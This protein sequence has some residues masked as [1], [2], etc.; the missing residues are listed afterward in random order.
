MKRRNLW[1]LGVGPLYLGQ[2]VG[3][4]GAQTGQRVALVIG[5]GAYRGG[6]PALANPPRDARAV[7]V[8][9]ERLGF[10][11]ELWLDADRAT[12]LAAF[13]RLGERATGAEAALLFYAGHAAEV[14]GRNILF[15]VSVSAG[16][17]GS[18][19]VRESVA[20]DDLSAALNGKARTTLIFL[21]LCRD[22]PLT[23]ANLPPA[24]T[25]GRTTG[26]PARSV[27]TGLAS[28]F[29]PAGTLIVYATAPGQVA[30]DGDGQ[31]SPFTTALLQHIETPDIEVRDMLTRVRRVVRQ[32]TQGRQIPWDNSSLDAPFFM[33]TGSSAGRS[34][35]PS[36]RI[37]E[38]A[39]AQ[40][41]TLPSS[42]T[43]LRFQRS[44]EPGAASQFVGSWSSG[45]QRWAGQSGRRNVLIVLSV[46]ERAGT[47][48]TIFAQ[49]EYSEDVTP[50]NGRGNQELGSYF[51]RRVM[52]FSSGNGALEATSPAGDRMQFI[53]EAETCLLQSLERLLT[54]P[55]LT[56]GTIF[57][58]RS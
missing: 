1:G 42:I 40:G 43:E 28:V 21:D 47:A 37:I 11:I 6:I 35:G 55:G 34:A 23:G 45:N 26:A 46:D 14:S 57:A 22:N 32:N 56:R 5:N 38:E 53:C 33:R 31:N 8:A 25:Q 3:F 48:E 13:R 10:Q 7:S 41:I 49:S 54:P 18:D 19:L 50:R 20:Y 51:R 52:S 2:P 30:L 44:G 15:T 36:R 58:R 16:R 17:S 39:A 29:S 12:M 24:A 9:I 4:A 27:G